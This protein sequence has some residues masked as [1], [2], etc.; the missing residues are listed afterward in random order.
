MA[1]RVHGML[2][3][4][5]LPSAS[6]KLQHAALPSFTAA[7]RRSEWEDRSEWDDELGGSGRMASSVEHAANH[8]S[9]ST[10]NNFEDGVVVD[11]DGFD[12][13]PL[14]VPA[15]ERR[16]LTVG[17]GDGAIK[18][19]ESSSSSSSAHVAEERFHY[20]M[21]ALDSREK[22]LEN[23]G[24][25]AYLAD[26]AVDQNI[27]KL[28]EVI[29]SVDNTLNRCLQ[30]VARIG[31][32]HKQRLQIHQDVIRGLDSWPEMRGRF[33]SQ[34]SLMKGVAGIDQ[35]LHVFE[36][37][38]EAFVDG[39]LYNRVRSIVVSALRLLAQIYHGRPNSLDPL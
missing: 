17:N 27:D 37:S 28:R 25:G 34:R 6:A 31:K 30:S 5:G 14:P 38:D 20:G 11:D 19:V 10:S 29:G 12:L 16:I 1:L 21:G 35:S 32:A 24:G 23:E 33:V 36:E 7:A 15:P 2:E 22:P 13:L 18:P 3:T 8:A 4:T 26:I 39:K 9:S